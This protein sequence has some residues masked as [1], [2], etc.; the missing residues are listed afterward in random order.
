[1]QLAWCLVVSTLTAVSQVGVLPALVLIFHFRDVFT[2]NI[3]FCVVYVIV[4]HYLIHVRQLS[5]FIKYVGL[6]F[7]VM[8]TQWKTRITRQ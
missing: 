6:K 3:L 5:I 2:I 1:M 8:T 7:Y 4:L